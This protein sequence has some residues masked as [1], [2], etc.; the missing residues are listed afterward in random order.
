MSADGSRIAVG[1]PFSDGDD[2]DEDEQEANQRGTVRV[3][4]QPSIFNINWFQFGNDINGEADFDFFGYTLAMS[5][6]G[7][8]IAVGAIHNEEDANGNATA[9]GQ[10]KV[11]DHPSN[12]GEDCF[13]RLKHQRLPL[14]L[15]RRI[16]QALYHLCPP[17][18][19]HRLLPL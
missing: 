18:F 4:D 15:S 9:R 14:L 6:N 1:S 19:H 3:H 8:R 10:L 5:A 2:D 11:F 7:S 12:S 13:P 17:V 16:R